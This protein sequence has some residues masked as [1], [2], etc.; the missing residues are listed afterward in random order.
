MGDAKEQQSESLASTNKEQVQPSHNPSPEEP[1]HE[2]TVPPVNDVATSIEAADVIVESSATSEELAASDPASPPPQVEEVASEAAPNLSERTEPW[3]PPPTPV[4]EVTSLPLPEITPTTA[5]HVEESS[6]TGECSAKPDKGKGRA[7]LAPEPAEPTQG[8]S[9]LSPQKSDG[10][11]RVPSI[12][13]TNASGSRT[14]RRYSSSTKARKPVKG[15]DQILTVSEGPDDYPHIHN[16]RSIS[17]WG[18]LGYQP[19]RNLPRPRNMSEHHPVTSY[20]GDP[21]FRLCS[22]VPYIL[23]PLALVT[24]LQLIVETPILLPDEVKDL[25]AKNGVDV[26]SLASYDLALLNIL[27][28]L[29][30]D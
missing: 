29:W 1:M 9:Y 12:R 14:V 24:R 30:G 2:A 18:R 13:L 6:E 21:L 17:R 16:P 26:A 22:S 5:G 15:S 7:V 11:L 3:E 27:G 20:A 23:G 28:C 19:R 8:A 25:V 10:L 4:D